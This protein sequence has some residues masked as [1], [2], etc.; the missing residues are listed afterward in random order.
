VALAGGRRQDSAELMKTL[1]G[2]SAGRRHAAR[3]VIVVVWGFEDSE[4]SKCSEYSNLYERIKIAQNCSNSVIKFQP[5]KRQSSKL[6]V[7]PG[8]RIFPH[9]P[10]SHETP[11]PSVPRWKA[12]W[13]TKRM[14]EDS[15]D[16]LPTSPRP[17]R[18]S[19]RLAARRLSS[20]TEDHD[21][22]LVD[23]QRMSSHCVHLP[24]SPVGFPTPRSC[25]FEPLVLELDGSLD[26][27][28][29]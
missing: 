4:S 2:C 14:I 19:P 28:R 11:V 26:T 20:L 17:V 13:T 8:I 16:R 22:R 3:W 1:R 23:D 21:I 27:P 25:N 18:R 29:T 7:R 10:S 9:S 15:P 24:D 5:V 12:R 6:A